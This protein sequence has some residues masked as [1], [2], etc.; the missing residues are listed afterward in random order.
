MP[1]PTQNLQ[2]CAE[3]FLGLTIKPIVVS[4]VADVQ[5]SQDQIER[6]ALQLLENALFLERRSTQRT[7]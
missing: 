5:E 2:Y 4:A 3:T 7:H 6:L 1:S